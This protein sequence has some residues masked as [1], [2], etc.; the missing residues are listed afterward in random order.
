MNFNYFGIASCSE[1]LCFTPQGKY[2]MVIYGTKNCVKTLTPRQA[3]KW[4]KE[5][6][7]R[8]SWNKVVKEANNWLKDQKKAA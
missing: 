7:H 5:R 8:S 6:F 1:D 3:E 4:Y 2:V